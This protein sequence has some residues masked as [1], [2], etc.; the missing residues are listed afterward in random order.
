MK[1]HI[2]KCPEFSSTLQKFK[3]KK[4]S[5]HNLQEPDS[6]T[7]VKTGKEVFLW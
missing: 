6:T 3:D 5:P 7:K 1:Q 4:V 2:Y